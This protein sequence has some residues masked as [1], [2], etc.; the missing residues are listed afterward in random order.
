LQQVHLRVEDQTL[1]RL[2]DTRALVF[3]FKTYL[4]SLEDV[5]QE[6][7]GKV[8]EE[9]AQAIEGLRKGSVPEMW[10]YKR[11]VVWGARVCKYLRK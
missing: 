11:G 10:H 6:E 3:A 1:F 9:L 7:D 8:A 5:K 4:Y 2:P